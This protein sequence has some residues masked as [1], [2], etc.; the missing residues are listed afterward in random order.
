M[1]EKPSV[2]RVQR[3]WPSQPTLE[4][5]GVHLRRAFGFQQVPQLDPFLLLDDFHSANPDDYRRGFPWHPHRGIET[6]TYV[7][8]GDIEHQDSLGNGGIISSGDVQWMTAGGGILHQEMPKGDG[9]G[10]MWGFQL[11]ANLPASDKMMVPRYREVRRDDIPTVKTPE[12]ALLRVIAGRVAGE[13]GPVADIVTDPELLDV[14]VPSGTVFAH[15]VKPGHNV[16]AYVIEGEG[17]FEPEGEAGAEAPP[18]QT[19]TLVLYGPGESIV[20]STASKPVRFILASG[21]PIGEP[22]AWAGPIV[23]NT[24][25]ELRMAFQEIDRGTFVKRPA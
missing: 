12:G 14:S 2:R 24:Q 17:T 6:I 5:A 8:D 13:G 10:L 3:V 11:W 1:S 20:V 16:F 21:K 19:H 15:E 4:G 25:E 18:A 23:M 7:L 22:V 9:K